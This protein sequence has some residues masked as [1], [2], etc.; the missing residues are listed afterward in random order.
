MFCNPHRHNYGIDQGGIITIWYT[1]HMWLP[2]A[3]RKSCQG[4]GKEMTGQDDI[5]TR[6]TYVTVVVQMK[7]IM[8]NLKPYLL[9]FT[10]SLMR[11]LA[12]GWYSHRDCGRYF[13]DWNSQNSKFRNKLYFPWNWIYTNIVQKWYLD[14]VQAL[15]MFSLC[16]FFHD[17]HLL[18]PSDVCAQCKTPI[19]CTSN[20]Q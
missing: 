10:T 3:I 5:W 14:L 12:I 19:M 6:T 16:S 4:I 17:R 8:S 20:Q 13:Y 18:G 11:N 9:W 7:I 1:K 15:K 2:A